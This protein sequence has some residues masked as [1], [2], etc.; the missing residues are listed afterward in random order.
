MDATQLPAE[1]QFTT[2]VLGVIVFTFDFFLRCA[3]PI[4]IVAIIAYRVGER[5]TRPE[6]DES[7]KDSALQQ[8]TRH[9]DWR[10]ELRS[11]GEEE[12]QGPKKNPGECVGPPGDGMRRTP[13]AWRCRRQQPAAGA[14]TPIRTTEALA[15]G[16][17]ADD[18]VMAGFCNQNAGEERQNLQEVMGDPSMKRA[19]AE[20]NGARR[21]RERSRPCC[22]R[23]LLLLPRGLVP[24]AK[25]Q[26]HLAEHA[27]P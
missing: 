1:P 3:V 18:V 5:D 2:T 27:T 22:C 6:N 12:R 10:D 9:I 20:G 16:M 7:A 23:R 14:T 13:S 4:I 17:K 21:E 11:D 19:E 25:V 8:H 24:P 15:A 26:V